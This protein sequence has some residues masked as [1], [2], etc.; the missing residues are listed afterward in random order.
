MSDNEVILAQNPPTFQRKSFPI[1]TALLAASLGLVLSGLILPTLL[2]G[3]KQ[4]LTGTDIKA[5]WYLSRG[6]AIMGYLLMWFSM[7]WGLLI[8]SKLSK[9]WPGP[10]AAND[11][12]K[13]I[14]L[15]GMGLGGMHAFLLLGDRYMNLSLTQI[16]I[17]FSIGIYRPVWVGIGQV[18]LYLTGIVIASFYLRKAFGYKTWRAIHFLTFLMFL[19]ILIHGIASGTDTSTQWMTGIYWFTG[20][21]ILFLIFYRVFSAMDTLKKTT[22]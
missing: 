12:H 21:S 19:L 16:L 8:T 7:V 20:G 9:I 1:A 22:G 11:F 13:F 6:T 10:Q 4:S 18:A 15:L 17:P 5:F 2:P 3:L 14:S